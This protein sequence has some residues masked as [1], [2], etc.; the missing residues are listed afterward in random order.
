MCG[1]LYLVWVLTCRCTGLSVFNWEQPSVHSRAKNIPLSPITL[2]VANVREQ[3]V[4]RKFVR[5]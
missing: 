3:K 2:S 5:H 4:G 1:I